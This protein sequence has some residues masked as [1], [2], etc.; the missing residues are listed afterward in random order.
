MTSPYIAIAAQTN[1][2]VINQKKQIINDII[3]RYLDLI[4]HCVEWHGLFGP[5]MGNPPVR[6]IAFP[7][8]FLQGWDYHHAPTFSFVANNKY[9]SQKDA[10]K[11][12][13]EIPGEETDMLAS[14]AREHNIYLCG[15]ALEYDPDWPGRVFNCAFIVDPNG[16]TIHKY[17]KLNSSN[18][19]IESATSPYDILDEYM[20]KYGKGRTISEVL[21][22]VTE[23]ELGRLGTYICWDRQFPEVARALILNGAEVLIHPIMTYT[24][25]FRRGDELYRI[26][27]QMRAFENAAYVISANSARTLNRPPEFPAKVP[28]QWTCGHSMIVDHSGRVLG[29]AGDLGEEMI[30]AAI[31]IQALRKRRSAPG[32]NMPAQILTEAYLDI[33]LR[34]SR[35][36]LGILP[37]KP[38][39]NIQEVIKEINESIEKLEKEKVYV[40]PI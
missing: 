26:N 30:A 25:A 11:V 6:L 28:E 23:T 21:F 20:A 12:A 13:I 34:L 24:G 17:R 7:E 5:R 29:E 33:Y 18:S 19:G 8:F 4:D 31:D 14:K 35:R 9:G 16:D 38:K 37:N 40:P 1:L 32:Y 2:L 22:P 36:K 27:N 39:D 3:P 10:L 15:A